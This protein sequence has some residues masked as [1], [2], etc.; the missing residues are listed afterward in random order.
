MLMLAAK[1]HA[2]ASGRGFATPDDVKT[3]AAPVLRHRLLL[4]PEFEVEGMK[5]DDCIRDLLAGIE[6]P[7]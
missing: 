3:M 7:R 5:P 6:V 2:V 4:L 1:A